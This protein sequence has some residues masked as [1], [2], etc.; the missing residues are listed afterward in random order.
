MASIHKQPGK[1]FWYAHFYCPTTG[2]R[3]CKSTKT[4]SPSRAIGIAKA[5]EA[6]S[7]IGHKALKSVSNC[8]A[9]NIPEFMSL[10]PRQEIHHSIIYL[11][12]WQNEIVYV[13]QSTKAQIR[14]A[15][16]TCDLAKTWEYA[17]V[18]ACPKKLL[19]EVERTLIIMLNPPHN[20]A[21]CS[22]EDRD[23]KVLAARRKLSNFLA[24]SEAMEWLARINSKARDENS[25][26]VEPEIIL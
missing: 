4:T 21:L 24:N 7:S 23:C 6:G 20:V 8:E 19:C 10:V 18:F 25:R 3:K 2:K 5:L 14:I 9:I 12:I 17:V 11:L 1:R 16:H 26:T 22:L 15:T 13:G